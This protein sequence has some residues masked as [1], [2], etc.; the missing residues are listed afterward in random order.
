MHPANSRDHAGAAAR[1]FVEIDGFRCYSPD[2]ALAEAD[3][4]SVGFDVTAEVE[5]SSFW[6]RSRNRILRRMVERFSD[7]S[8]QLDML[9]IGCGIGGV[10][11]ELRSLPNLR[12]TA[13]EIYLHGLRYAR[14]KFPD[15]D[16]IQLDA[17]DMPFRDDFDIVGAFDVLEHIEAD[18]RVIRGVHG[19]LRHGGIF[20]VTVPQYQWM[21]S[22]LDE[23]VHHKRRY[24]RSE[25]VGRLRRSD[26]N[27]LFCSSFV[28]ALFPAMAASR[29]IA[30]TRN[31]QEETRQ[32]FE[33]H[34][35][36]PPSLNRICDWAM[37][38]DEVALRAGFALPFG[39]SLLVVARK[40]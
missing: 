20:M 13:S 6:C 22:S 14:S 37:R 7:Q 32:A 25:L 30:R 4:P 3:Y 21:W 9:E 39:G 29:L 23:V 34:V 24:G 31:R 36:L 5:A 40:P 11:G 28:T 27:V 16:F 2:S 10:V 26:F 38:L 17:T 15:V 12:L 35:V 18:D 19:A 8:R 1:P 33:A